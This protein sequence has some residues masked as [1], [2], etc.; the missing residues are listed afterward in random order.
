M[1]APIGELESRADHKIF[2]GSRHEDLAGSRAGGHAGADMHSE[3]AD[4]LIHGLALTGVDPG[5]HVQTEETHGVP[6][7]D[8]ASHRSCRAIESCKEPVTGGL[9]LT[10][11]K[12]SPENPDN[13]LLWVK[14]HDRVQAG[15]MPP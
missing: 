7:R 2:D 14:V 1:Q 10:S 4:F 9:D 5:T 13:F 11:I 6:N 8:R 3:T 15:E 12:Y